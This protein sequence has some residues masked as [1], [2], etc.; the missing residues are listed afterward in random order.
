MKIKYKTLKNIDLNQLFLLYSD[1][2]WISYTNDMEKLSRAIRNSDFVISAWDDGKLVGIIR[3]FT[4]KETVLFIQD[5]IV[6]KSYQRQ[7]IGKKLID[8]VLNKNKVRQTILQTDLL[9]KD[10][11][12]FYQKLG[13]IKSQEYN[14]QSYVLYRK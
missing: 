7:G 14:T 11:N 5:I 2:E 4:D 12:A 8:I 10:S 9:D 13:F 6:L 1:A 3:G